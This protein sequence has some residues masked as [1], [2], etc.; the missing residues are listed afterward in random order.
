M[1]E[2]DKRQ[3]GRPFKSGA[4]KDVGRKPFGKPRGPGKGKPE[5]AAAPKA[6]QGERIAK[7]ISRHK[8]V[9]LEGVRTMSKLPDAIFLVDPK[10]EETAVQEARRLFLLRGWPVIDASHR[11]IEQTAAMIIDLLK[12]RAG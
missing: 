5:R 10:H 3:G 8:G 4:K 9:S 12:A 6:F 11:S 1:T 7:A 2:K